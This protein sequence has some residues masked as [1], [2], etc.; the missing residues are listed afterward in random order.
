MMK[1]LPRV[2]RLLLWL[3]CGRGANGISNG[4][5]TGVGVRGSF[6][7]DGTM[8]DVV[9]AG[10]DGDLGTT[11][12]G[13]RCATVSPMGKAVTCGVCDIGGSIMHV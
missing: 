1:R 4:R 12:D 2:H 8:T 6:G 3:W 5:S 10:R 9:D 7:Y 11:R 13:D